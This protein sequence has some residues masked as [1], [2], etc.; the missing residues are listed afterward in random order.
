MSTYLIITIMSI[1]SIKY[2]KSIIMSTMIACLTR[3]A[4][5]HVYI[6]L[7]TAIMFLKR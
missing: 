3:V 1:N 4:A 2:P 6:I 5:G 7:V